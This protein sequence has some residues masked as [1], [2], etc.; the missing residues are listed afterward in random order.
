MEGGRE[1]VVREGQG[2]GWVEGGTG[3]QMAGRRGGGGKEGSSAIIH[4]THITV[5][6]IRVAL[7]LPAPLPLPTTST[8]P[9]PSPPP[10]PSNHIHPPYNSP[11]PLLPNVSQ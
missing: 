8:R 9:P 11:T 5:Y 2:N 4:N 3:R 1:G 7:W 6:H 10:A